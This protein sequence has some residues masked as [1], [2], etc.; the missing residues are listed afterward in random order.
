M[1]ERPNPAGRTAGDD[2]A[3]A[4]RVKG[5]GGELG[6]V[7]VGV[8]RAEKLGEEGERLTAWLAAGHHG[9]MGYMQRTAEV[10]IDPTHPGMLP[11]ARSVVVFA[12]PY[13][14]ARDPK[15]LGRVAR[16][17]Q[18]R[19]Y[20]NVLHKRLRHVTRLLR[21]EGHAARAAVD[22]LPV[23]ERAWAQRAGIGFIGKNCCLIV[24]GLGSHLFLAAVV[25]SAELPPDQPMPERC[26]ACRLCLDVCP[27]RAFVAPRSMDARRCISYLTIEHRGAIDEELRPAI[28]DWIFGCDACQDVCPFNRGA[29]ASEA[30]GG[31]SASDTPALD[32]AAVLELDEPSFAAMTAGSPLRRPKREGLAR[33]AAIVL[34]NHGTRRALPLLERVAARDP[35]PIVRE[36][37]SWAARKIAERER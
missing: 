11:G 31:G 12:A 21:A 18:G 24:P 6:F 29:A 33:N 36:T 23:F 27:T 34:G 26:G 8:A 13:A 14:G 30:A 1:G 16:Y 20:H 25:T 19:D 4:A 37:A 32:P 10:R 35:S 17:A 5:L 7:R 28:A 22:S 3:L 2:E 15:K 9:D